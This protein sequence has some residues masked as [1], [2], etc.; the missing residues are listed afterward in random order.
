MEGNTYTETQK[1]QKIIVPYGTVQ[2]LHSSA[3]WDYKYVTPMELLR[4]LWNTESKRQHLQIPERAILSVL[5]NHV[6]LRKAGQ[7]GIYDAYPSVESIIALTGIT[8]RTVRE[9]RKSLEAQDWVRMH[10]GTGKGRNN[11]YFINA[12]KIVDCYHLSNPE[13]RKYYRTGKAFEAI[14]SI[15]FPI[16]RNTSGLR[17]GKSVTLPAP[18]IVQ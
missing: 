7:E 6:D 17:H 10:S 3:K 14:E 8:E 2:K 11:H 15:P 16:N 13:D 9:H 12:R 1:H 4:L 18:S 5:L